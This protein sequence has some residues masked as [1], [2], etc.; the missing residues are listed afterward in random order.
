MV[1]VNLYNSACGW[2]VLIH[3]GVKDSARDK[4]HSG[5][6]RAFWGLFQ[7]SRVFWGLFLKVQGVLGTFS[8]VQRVLGTFFKSSDHSHGYTKEWTHIP[9]HSHE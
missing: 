6:K 7:K 2:S 4:P 3:A 8:K 9:I 5:D 1:C